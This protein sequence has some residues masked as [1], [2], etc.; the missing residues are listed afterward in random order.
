MPMPNRLPAVEGDKVV[1]AVAGHSA[2][3]CVTAECD[4]HL[5]LESSGRRVAGIV[6][7]ATGTVTIQRGSTVVKRLAFYT[8]RER[9]GGP[10]VRSGTRTSSTP[11]NEAVN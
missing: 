10:C 2:I 4:T 5:C 7:L 11:T 3:G 8:R 9:C 1:T 6:G